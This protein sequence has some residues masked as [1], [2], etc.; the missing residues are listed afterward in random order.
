MQQRNARAR[1]HTHNADAGSTRMQARAGEPN[2]STHPDGRVHAVHTK[3]IN[4]ARATATCYAMHMHNVRPS[5]S[6]R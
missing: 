3:H 6:R 2:A 5:A 1:A 4:L